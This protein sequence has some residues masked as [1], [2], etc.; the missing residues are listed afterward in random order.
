MSVVSVVQRQLEAY[1]EHDLER[2]VA[3]YS[4]TVQIFRPPV[5]QPAISGK[6][7]LSEFYGSQRFSLPALKA[8]ILN[9]MVLGTRV[10]DHERIWTEKWFGRQVVLRRGS[11]HAHA[12]RVAACAIQWARARRWRAIPADP[13]R[14][15]RP[16]IRGAIPWPDAGSGSQYGC[17]GPP[18][19]AD[20][21]RS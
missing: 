3:E 18:H 16:A 7:Q 1:N 14:A 21:R 13:R 15:D 9:R 20:E 4:D 11:P 10:V 12:R 6:A 17:H 5:V 2:F 8:D 19:G